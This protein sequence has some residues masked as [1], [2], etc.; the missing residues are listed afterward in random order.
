VPA[1]RHALAIAVLPGTVTVVVPAVIL[2]L[3]EG[4]RIGW[5]LGGIGERALALLGVV[6]IGVGLALWTWTV[7]LFARRGRGT[8][9]PWDPTRRLVIEGPYQH[10]RNPMIS[11]V[12]AILIGE[13]ALLGSLGLVIWAAGFLAL[14]HAYLMLVEEPGL[15]RRFGEEYRRYREQVPRWVPRADR[16]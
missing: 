15:E 11:A 2:A 3:G 13:A 16:G 1:W 6:L 4:P 5:E 14:N 12:L 9:A 7:V 10:V 8:L